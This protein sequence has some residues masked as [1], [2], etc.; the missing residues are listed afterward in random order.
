M[1]QVGT[2]I[3]WRAGVQLKDYSLLSSSGQNFLLF[4]KNPNKTSSPW[5]T[6]TH[7]PLTLAD[8]KNCSRESGFREPEGIRG[9]DKP[10]CPTPLVSEWVSV[11]ACVCARARARS[12]LSD[13]CSPMDCS[14]S[15]SSVNGIFQASTGAGCDFLLQGIFSTQGSNPCLLC[16][17][18]RQQ[19]LQPTSPHPKYSFKQM[20]STRAMMNTEQCKVMAWTV[21]KGGHIGEVCFSFLKEF[22]RPSGEL[23]FLSLVLLNLLLD[24]SRNRAWGVTIF[25]CPQKRNAK[26]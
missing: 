15:G 19:F 23:P 24:F 12:V 26:G 10:F 1:G 16:P 17:L 8:R 22:S 7:L 6:H 9:Q 18:Q 11:C 5:H 25:R 13:S 21:A 2:A 3:R 4:L 20:H 14:P